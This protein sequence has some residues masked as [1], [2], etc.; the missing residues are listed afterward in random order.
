MKIN[1][2]EERR[3]GKDDMKINRKEERREVKKKGR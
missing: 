3:R 2:K 1:R